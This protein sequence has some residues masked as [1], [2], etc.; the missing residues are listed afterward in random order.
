VQHCARLQVCID[1]LAASEHVI[2]IITKC[3]PEIARIQKH[4]YFK[5]VFKRV[6]FV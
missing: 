3:M 1:T 6:L 4:F 2:I 5:S